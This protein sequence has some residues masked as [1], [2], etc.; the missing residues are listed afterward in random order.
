MSAHSNAPQLA[1]RAAPPN[2]SRGALLERVTNTWIAHLRAALAPL[3]L[4]PAQYQLLASAAWL[5]AR[6]PAVR[7][8]EISALANT[9]PVMTS[10]VLRALE[11]RRL[12]ARDPHPTD[13]RAKT[14]TVS[15]AGGALADRARRIVES[16]ETRF[17][18]HG[19]PDFGTLAK[20][21]KKGG[22]GETQK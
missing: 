10:E 22:R 1:A 8:S 12:I 9:D 14:I 6:Q 19:T 13:R 5:S 16:T 21:L 3:E 20:A 17:F 2:E 18:D 15:E 4:T 11:A 7:Q